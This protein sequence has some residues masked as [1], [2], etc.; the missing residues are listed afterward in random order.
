M[1]GF[2]Y[3]IHVPTMQSQRNSK[4]DIKAKSTKVEWTQDSEGKRRQE[5]A[6]WLEEQRKIM[7]LE[8]NMRNSGWAEP[9]SYQK[10]RSEDQCSKHGTIGHYC[11]DCYETRDKKTDGCIIC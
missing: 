10:V 4:F 3:R 2:R 6:K 11:S 5:E 1:K 8:T 9:K 7:K